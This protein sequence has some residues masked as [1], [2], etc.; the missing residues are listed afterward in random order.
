[1]KSKAEIA[2]IGLGAL[3]LLAGCKKEAEPDPYNEPYARMHDP[4]YLQMMKTQH[5]NQRGLM[6]QIDA[7]RQAYAAEKARDPASPKLADLQEQMEALSAE[8]LQNRKVSQEIIRQ[9]IMMEQEAIAAKKAAQKN[10]KK[11]K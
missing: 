9:R 1:M 2:M 4:R 6:R 11:G 8:I 10:V 7:V 3:V 5:E